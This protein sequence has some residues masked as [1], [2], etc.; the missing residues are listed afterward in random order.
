MKGN[1]AARKE[2]PL[3]RHKEARDRLAA[4]LS[5]YREILVPELQ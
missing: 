2:D 3:A 4:E 1:A 5:N